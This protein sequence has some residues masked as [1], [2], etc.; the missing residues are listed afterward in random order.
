V[1]RTAKLMKAY[2]LASLADTVLLTVYLQVSTAVI[3]FE[4]SGENHL[5]V[6]L[7]VAVLIAHS[8]A[9]R[10]TKGVYE[11]LVSSC[12]IAYQHCIHSTRLMHV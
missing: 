1:Q 2:L 10:L 6:P 5:R 3:V 8:I 4:M 7:G 9:S 11:S 12:A